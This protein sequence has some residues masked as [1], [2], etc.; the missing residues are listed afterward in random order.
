MT[1]ILADIVLCGHIHSESTF[2][3]PYLFVNSK[4]DIGKV[5]HKWLANA[6][7]GVPWGKIFNREIIEKYNIRFDETLKVGEDHVFTQN[8]LMHCNSLAMIEYSGY[9]YSID[10]H[11]NIKKY[12]L[13]DIES[14]NFLNK[15]IGTYNELKKEF[16]FENEKFYCQNVLFPLFKYLDYQSVNYPYSISGI[17]KAVRFLTTLEI[18]IN[19]SSYING[20]ISKLSFLLIIKKQLKAVVI[21]HRFVIPTIRKIKSL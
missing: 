20:I 15:V 19:A 7:V 2:H 12:I 4:Q 11:P 5:L 14:K 8:Y 10:T 21:L 6:P 9:Y 18:P 17:D 16:N 1:G 13:S 3:Y